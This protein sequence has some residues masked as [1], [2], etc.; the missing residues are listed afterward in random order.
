M[1][2]SYQIGHWALSIRRKDVRVTEHEHEQE[3]EQEHEYCVLCTVYIGHRI[4][5]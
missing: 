3:H 2:R 4:N 1:K 5:M